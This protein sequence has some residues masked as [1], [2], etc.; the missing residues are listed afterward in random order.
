MTILL[1]MNILFFT[2]LHSDNVQNPLQYHL[3]G[4]VLSTDNYTP[5]PGAHIFTEDYSNG[6][7]SDENGRFHLMINSSIDQLIV[8]HISFETKRL[9]VDTSKEFTFYEIMMDPIRQN[10][11][12]ELIIKSGRIQ[13][14]S[15]GIYSDVK[16][17]PVEDHLHHIPGLNLISRANFAKD[18][19]IRGL[20]DGRVDVLIDGMRMTPACVDGMDPLTA[21]VE[22]DNLQS[23]E[24]E[25]GHSS[26]GASASASGGALNFQMATPALHTGLEVGLEA[27]Y[28]SVSSQQVYQ[29]MI[30]YGD[31]N[32][33]VRVSGTYRNADD[34]IAG[35]GRKVSG[36]SFEKGNIYTSVVYEPSESHHFGLQYIGD[37]AGN[38]GYPALIMDTQRADAHLLGIEHSW[39]SPISYMPKIKTRIYANTV[40]HTMN[41][42]S[43]NVADRDVMRNM[44]MPMSGETYTYGINTTAA[45]LNGRHLLDIKAETY[46]LEAFADMWMHHTSPDVSD[47]Y[48]VNLG[49]IQNWNSSISAGYTFFLDNGWRLG[50]D[51]RLEAGLNRIREKSAISTY[52]AEYPDLD[53]LNPSEI[54]HLAGMNAEKDFSDRFTA[55]MR[56]SDGYRMPGHNERYGYY[57][58]QPLDGYFYIGNPGLKPE[59]SS[60]AELFITYGGVSSILRGN[61][62]IWINRM[63]NYISG[64]RYGYD[65]I[66][67]K[68][69]NMGVALLYGTETE[70]NL[71]PHVNWDVRAGISYVFGYH[72][73]VND[74]LPMIPPLRGS[75][76]VRKAGLLF[77]IEAHLR[78]S[79]SQARIA[80][81]NSY[82]TRTP[83]YAITDLFARSNI[84]DSIILQIG[85]ENILDNY[86]TD[87]LNVNSLP[88]PGRNFQFSIRYAL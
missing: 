66:F 56:I 38:I 20:R 39:N 4:V 41:D 45:L 22:S 7:I 59:R 21:Y 13:P 44:Y 46:L 23:I 33:G 85:L 79:A 8:S 1:L 65:S 28:Q 77:D 67:K 6:S 57:V 82:E 26:K 11:Q 18:P 80:A 25:R 51:V 58:Y 37:F 14:V 63:D 70:F 12:G 78:W 60:Q 29:G 86:F 31:H 81:V 52:R 30:S 88:N 75:V 55:G 84:S 35:K 49:D 9:S 73:E 64:N 17:R 74:P 47:M 76:S 69:Q 42:Y 43:R 16:T 71:S 3:E 32:W 83:G 87:H 2:N 36:S 5:V 54:V 50:G 10:M 61:T 62:A 15:S 34:M 24:V 72:N 53:D 48:L 68:Y 27:G 40:S 19:V